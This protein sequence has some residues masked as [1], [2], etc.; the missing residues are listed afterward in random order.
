LW[1]RK[2][3]DILEALIRLLGRKVGFNTSSK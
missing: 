3:V 2:K 1:T